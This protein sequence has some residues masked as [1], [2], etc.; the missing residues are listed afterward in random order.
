[1]LNNAAGKFTTDIVGTG[2][3]TLQLQLLSP[4]CKLQTVQVIGSTTGSIY[5]NVA[6]IGYDAT[7]S[8]AITQLVTVPI[9]PAQD[10]QYTITWNAASTTGAFPFNIAA[11]SAP[12]VMGYPALGQQKSGDSA[13]VT[14]AV[15]QT[16][17][18]WQTAA[19][20]VQPSLLNNPIGGTNPI[21][22]SVASGA[23]VVLLAA[24]GGT[25]VTYLHACA[26]TVDAAPAGDTESLENTSGTRI[27]KFGIG[28]TPPTYLGFGSGITGGLGI[29]LHNESTGA[30][31]F[32]GSLVDAQR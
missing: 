8:G 9:N 22:V 28:M 4:G 2:D 1:M 16:G 21:S 30:S 23:T 31:F 7:D 29:Q 13:P 14:L 19:P 3:Q 20:G 18:P 26:I 24:P 15:D 10:S 17:M 12:Q 11:A 25:T 32:R 5:A 27:H 6:A